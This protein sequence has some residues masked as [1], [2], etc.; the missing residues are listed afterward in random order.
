MKFISLCLFML[1]SFAFIA[2]AADVSS[3]EETSEEELKTLL[4][5]EKYILILFMKSK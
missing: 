4:K 3:L 1:L 5:E 2:K